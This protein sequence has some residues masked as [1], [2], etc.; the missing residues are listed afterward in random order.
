[1]SIPVSPAARAVVAA[2]PT[3]ARSR[4]FA[5]FAAI[6]ALALTALACALGS[7]QWG[8]LKRLMYETPGRDGWQMPDRVVDTLALA[9]GQQVADVG[10]G[11]GYFTFRLAQAVGTAGRVYAVDLDPDL[12]AYV[13]AQAEARALPQVETILA[14]PTDTGLA[15]STVDLV[16]LAH[17]FHHI[18]APA[19]YFARVSAALRPGGRV[20]IVEA[21]SDEPG[22]GHAT[23]PAA[24]ED[25][26]REAGFERV[27]SHGFLDGQSYQVFALRSGARTTDE[28][29]H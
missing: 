5:A 9:A 20:A 1:M 3:R 10:A 17:V 24:I 28:T 7:S 23:P 15:E 21:S 26:L 11:G 16:F 14:S 8:G 13:A 6:G 19:E 4:R 25:A 22:K 29:S 27:A 18:E 12:L 2:P